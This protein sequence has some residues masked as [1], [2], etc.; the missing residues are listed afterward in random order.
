M[1]RRRCVSTRTPC[2]P[3]PAPPDIVGDGE[4]P[5]AWML[6]LPTEDEWLDTLRPL[7]EDGEDDRVDD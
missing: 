1:P 7:D 3:H 5:W 6:D 2:T 4:P